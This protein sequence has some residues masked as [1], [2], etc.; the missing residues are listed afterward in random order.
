MAD[1]A[2]KVIDRFDPEGKYLGQIT[3]TT[4]GTPLIFVYGIAVDASGNLWVNEGPEEFAQ[5]TI[6]E[7]GA[8]GAFVKSFPSEHF[9]GV[10]IPAWRWT[11]P[12][13]CS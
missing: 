7:L 10:S 1:V 6:D 13:T 8:T 4:T 3:E 9:G 2:N 12:A 5:S 11:R